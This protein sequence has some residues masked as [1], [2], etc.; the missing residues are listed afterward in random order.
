VPDSCI[1]DAGLRHLAQTVRHRWGVEEHTLHLF[2]KDQVE[3]MMR[4]AGFDIVRCDPA[5]SNGVL[6][7]VAPD[8]PP[9][10]H[11]AYLLRRR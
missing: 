11:F 5:P 10:E 4:E 3:T 6:T 7:W 8:E 2:N 9:V 1:E